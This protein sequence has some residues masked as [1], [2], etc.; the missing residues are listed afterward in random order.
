MNIPVV[1]PQMGESVAE[2]T[3]TKWLKRP[4]DNVQRDEP[5]LE[6]STDKVDSEIPAPATG[7][8]REIRAGGERAVGGG[9][10]PA[11]R[12]GRGG[13]VARAT[14]AGGAAERAAARGGP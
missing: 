9:G 4:G 7:V 8:V 2:G 12:E 13:A 3:V 5:L 1:M 10:V 6:I 11:F 14:L